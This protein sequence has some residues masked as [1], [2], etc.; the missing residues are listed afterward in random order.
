MTTGG[1]RL[2]DL[3]AADRRATGLGDDVLALRARYVPDKAGTTGHG[4]ARGAGFQK[5]DILIEVDGQSH[6]LTESQW[7]TW[8]INA[9]KVG[10]RIK[11][12]VLRDGKRLEFELPMQ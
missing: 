10:D 11:V 6:R 9:K 7:M 4:A 8:L 12:A 3:P 5:G 2:D 1:M